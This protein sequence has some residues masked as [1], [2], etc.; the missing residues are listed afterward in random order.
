MK[1]YEWQVLQN[2]YFLKDVYIK[3]CYADLIP[4]EAN[5]NKSLRV[6]HIITIYSRVNVFQIKWWAWGVHRVNIGDPIYDYTP[7]LEITF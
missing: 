2:N 5:S 1:I 6:Y 7:W 3:K 4:N